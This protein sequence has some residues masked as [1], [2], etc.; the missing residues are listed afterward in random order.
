M[1]GTEK[2]QGGSM[3]ILS[4]FFMITFIKIL[5]YKRP[6]G[7]VSQEAFNS[8]A[9]STLHK[10]DPESLAPNGLQYTK[11]IIVTSPLKRAEE[12]VE[13]N[14]TNT[15]IVIDE[16]KEI[17]FDLKKLVSFEEWSEKGSPLV[18]KRFLEAF[19]EDTLSESRGKILEDTKNILRSILLYTKIFNKEILIISHSFRLIIIEAFI[20]SKGSL[21]RD[22]KL[23]GNFLKEEKKTYDFGKGFSVSREEIEKALLFRT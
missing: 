16:L 18:R 12:C 2:S 9:N 8:L 20:K 3:K 5:D 23:L 6:T 15:Y 22:P 21:E 13:I 7:D 1:R 19:V 4:P 14:S 10:V 11:K 17:I